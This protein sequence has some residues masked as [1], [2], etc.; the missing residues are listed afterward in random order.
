M[1][2]TDSKKADRNRFEFFRFP[3]TVIRIRLTGKIV[4]SCGMRNMAVN[5]RMM[6]L[7]FAGMT[8]KC[9][10]AEQEKKK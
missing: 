4:V 3:V 9:R 7:L 2:G 1:C 5:K 6:A 10:K 8:V